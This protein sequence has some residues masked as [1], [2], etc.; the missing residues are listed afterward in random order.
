MSRATLDYSLS[1]VRSLNREHGQRYGRLADF[2]ITHYLDKSLQ[3]RKLAH[4]FR[5]AS[6]CICSL[7]FTRVSSASTP[8][9]P[10]SWSCSCPLG[11]RWPS[12]WDSGRSASDVVPAR[13]TSRTCRRRREPPRGSGRPAGWRI[14]WWGRGLEF[15]SVRDL[16][17]SKFI[18]KWSS[19]P[20]V[21]SCGSPDRTASLPPSLPVPP[22]VWP[23][24]LVPVALSLV[25]A[26]GTFHQDRQQATGHP[27]RDDE[28]VEL[29]LHLGGGRGEQHEG[30][31]QRRR[32]TGR[33]HQLGPIAAEQYQLSHSR[34][35]PVIGTPPY[36]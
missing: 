23:P 21:W 27:N 2:F 24:D 12:G 11:W 9:T 15:I 36:C 18:S 28:G 5:R 14:V 34:L 10:P 6:T 20:V 8:A 13:A 3:N 19:R 35:L 31:Q 29:H 26:V 4:A 7:V 32:P 22:T 25:A 1:S 16:R 33:Q 17:A 30:Q